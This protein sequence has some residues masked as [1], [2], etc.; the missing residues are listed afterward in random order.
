MIICSCNVFS[1]VDVRRSLRGVDAPRSARAV[2]DLLGCSPKCGVC[3][4]TIRK[5]MKTER[6]LAKEARTS[7]CRSAEPD[8]QIA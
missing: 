6:L 5:I 3:V 1:D 2:Y 4:E 8:V 7:C